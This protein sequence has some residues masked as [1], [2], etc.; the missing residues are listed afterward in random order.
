[1]SRTLLFITLIVLFSFTTPPTKNYQRISKKDSS[2]LYGPLF[3]TYKATN[4]GDL[5]SCCSYGYVRSGDRQYYEGF[6]GIFLYSSYAE[7]GAEDFLESKGVRVKKASSDFYSIELYE[8]LLNQKMFKGEGSKLAPWSNQFREYNPK[9]I[10]GL[11]NLIPSKNLSINGVS[12]KALYR[13]FSRFFRLLTESYL[14]LNKDGTYAS[15]AENY[16]QDVQNG[17][18]G[19]SVLVRSYHYEFD[20]AY[21]RPSESEVSSPFEAHMAFGFW[22]RRNLDGTHDEIYDVLKTIMYRFDKR[23]YMS[24]KRKY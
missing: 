3:E 7:Q 12:V 22:L 2:V 4:E 13:S 18:D 1:M 8:R 14:Y 15:Q 21:A 11:K 16:I 10:N 9:F 20:E 5:S 23:W 19:L 6:K 24:V 17:E